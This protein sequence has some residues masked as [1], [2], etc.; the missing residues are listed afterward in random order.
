MPPIQLS[1]S[2]CLRDFYIPDAKKLNKIREGLHVTRKL[3]ASKKLA[4]N[5]R[6]EA[7][8]RKPSGENQTDIALPYQVSQAT[9]SRL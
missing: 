8:R 3:R 5:V 2:S 1:R 9:I 6:Q 4:L 7:L